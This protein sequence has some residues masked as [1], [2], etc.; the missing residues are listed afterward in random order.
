[1]QGL[2]GDNSSATCRLNAALW[3]RCLVMA[4]ILRKPSKG[5]NSNRPSC[6][7]AG[8]HSRSASKI[9]PILEPGAAGSARFDL[10]RGLIEA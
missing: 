2:A 8:A 3:D 6:P 4:S 1:M 9:D 7:P 5:V 10:A